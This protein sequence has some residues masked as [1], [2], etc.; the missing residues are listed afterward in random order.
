M[1]SYLTT[2]KFSS[3]FFFR[4]TYNKYFPYPFA[5]VAIYILFRF[6]KFFWIECLFIK[7]NKL[8]HLGDFIYWFIVRFLGNARILCAL[9]FLYTPFR[10]KNQ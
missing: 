1:L 2:D 3:T 5:I 4:F 6:I 8:C 7:N 9:T 10:I